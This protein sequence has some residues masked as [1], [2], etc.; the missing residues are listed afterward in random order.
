M[1]CVSAVILGVVMCVV[2][3]VSPLYGGSTS[4]GR[5]AMSAMLTFD[6]ILQGKKIETNRP[7]IKLIYETGI[8]ESG[9]RVRKQCK[10]PALGYWQMEPTTAWD[11]LKNYV[12]YNKDLY[13]IIFPYIS[14]KH[15]DMRALKHLLQYNNIFGLLMTY[16]HYKRTMHGEPIDTRME[17]AKVWKKYY[18]TRYGKGTIEKYMKENSYVS[19]RCL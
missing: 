3:V 14:I 15:T 10:G 4:G 6:S 13:D 17:R 12:M 18:N 5:C 1:R 19:T 9:Y 16:I 8:V 2:S 7:L 11:I